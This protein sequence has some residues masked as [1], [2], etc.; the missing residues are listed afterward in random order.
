MGIW[1]KRSILIFIDVSLIAA[2]IFIEN[3]FWLSN[4]LS[5]TCMLKDVTGLSCALCGGTHAVAA[6]VSGDWLSALRW[7]WY[8]VLLGGY[9]AVV[10][11]FAHLRFFS[12]NRV[13]KRIYHH[14]IHYRVF[15]AAGVLAAV[16]MAAS[17][18]YSIFF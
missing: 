8:V 4:L 17:N 15:I 18:L 12:D 9:L 5:P 7:N 10:L 6:A 1:L 11:V 16:Y 2:V 3:L 13:I 14:M